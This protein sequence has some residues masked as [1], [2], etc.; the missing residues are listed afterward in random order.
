MGGRRDPGRSSAW[1]QG[2]IIRRQSVVKLRQAGGLAILL[3]LDRWRRLRWFLLDLMGGRILSP[4]VP[5]KRRG[6][7][8]RPSRLHPFPAKRPSVNCVAREGRGENLRYEG[9]VKKCPKLALRILWT[10]PKCL[11]DQPTCKRK[12]GN[13]LI[14]AIKIGGLFNS[15]LKVGPCIAKERWEI[16]K[17]WC[18]K[19]VAKAISSM[20]DQLDIGMAEL[21]LDHFR[22]KSR[23]F[24]LCWN[25]TK[26][27]SQQ[28]CGTYA[29]VIQLISGR[30]WAAPIWTARHNRKLVYFLCCCCFILMEKRGNLMRRDEDTGQCATFFSILVRKKK[31]S[32]APIL[33]IDS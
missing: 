29:T 26:G 19:C 8:D 16:F 14:Q 23:G 9:R 7:R 24:L 30:F 10:V 33:A 22:R 31:W 13:C 5:V 25:Q 15:L 20:P 4:S 27:W 28:Q 1:G 6:R 2:R 18:P 11:K 32:A 3:L 12:V 17:R 21:S